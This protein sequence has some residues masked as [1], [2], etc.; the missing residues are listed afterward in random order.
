M[1][2]FF[3]LILSLLFYFKSESQVRLRP[4]IFG[5]IT[6]A[7][8]NAPLAG[9]SVTIEDAKLGTITDSS[10]KFIFKN[11]PSGHHLI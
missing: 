8:T 9:A 1:K 11:V 5:K 7:K 3:I 6:D 10:G 2:E 4:Q